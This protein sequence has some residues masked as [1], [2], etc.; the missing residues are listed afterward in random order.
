MKEIR[1]EEDEAD[2]SFDLLVVPVGSGGTLA[3]LLAGAQRYGFKGRIV[4]IP[5]CHD[6]EF[7]AT[8]VT[9]LLEGIR[10]D[11]LDDLDPVV[12]IGTL[13]DGFVGEGYGHATFAELERIR[14]LAILTGI[15]LDPVYTNKAFG[16]LLSLVR[17]GALTPGQR[18]LFLHTG[19]LF[20]VFPYGDK[21]PHLMVP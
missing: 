11:H 8:K 12:P 2:V 18:A 6:A 9:T 4:G 3:G 13:E 15:I 21:M 5:V 1:N 16:A 10:R 14:D 7:F 19:G 17:T 20:G